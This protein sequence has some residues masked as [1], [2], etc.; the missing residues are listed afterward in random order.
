MKELNKLLQRVH[1]KLPTARL[2]ELFLEVDNARTN[3]LDFDGFR[4][5]YHNLVHDDTVFYDFFRLYSGDSKRITS[6]EFTAFLSQEQRDP[7]SEDERTVNKFMLDYLRDSSRKDD[8]YFTV[9]EFLDFLFSKENEVWDRRH[10][11]VN[12]DMDR[13]LTHYWIASSHNTYLT[14]DQVRSESST[15]AYARCLRSGCRCVERE[16]NLLFYLF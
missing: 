4:K 1:S 12:Q 2:K 10:D 13:P 16:S 3:E 8:P 9:P 5:F 15:D 7:L 11:Q 14:G 6:P